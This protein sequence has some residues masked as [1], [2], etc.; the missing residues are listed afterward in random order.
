MVSQINWAKKNASRGTAS[1][2]LS[3]PQYL[4]DVSNDLS[5]FRYLVDDLAARVPAT[6]AGAA[7]L[8]NIVDMQKVH[9]HR[10]D[11]VERIESNSSEF[12]SLLHNIRREYLAMKSL[13]RECFREQGHLLCAGDWQSPVYA[14]S[15]E[16]KLNRLNAGIAEH[17]LDYKRD[18]HLEQAEYE[19]RFVA[20]YVS[21]LGNK[22]AAIAYLTNSGMAAY[23]TVLHWLAHEQGLGEVALAVEPMYFENIHLAGG[24][25]PNLVRVHSPS[26]DNLLDQLRLNNPSVVLVDA[27]TNCNDVIAQDLP[28]I[29]EWASKE[30]QQIA[31]VIDSTCVPTALLPDGFLA[32]IPDNVLIVFVESLAKHHQFGMD[33]VTG[34]VVVLCASTACHDSFRKTR[35]RF[36]GNITDV[37]AASLPQP[38]KAQL[39]ARMVRH[40]RNVRLLVEEVQERIEDHCGVISSFSWLSEPAEYAPNFHGSCFTIHLH[41]QFKSIDKYRQF[42]EQ[43]L[44]LAR[45]RNLPLSLSTSFGF[46]VSRLYVTA[47]STPFEPPFLRVAIGT[48]TVEEIEEF[49]DIIATV[50]RLLALRWKAPR[51]EVVRTAP[52]PVRKLDNG[53]R[54][55]HRHN[56]F[57]GDAAIK[58]YLN[59]ANYQKTPLVEL[60]PDLNPYADKGV[61][62]FAKLMPLVP[63]MNIKSIPAFSML[64]KAAQRGELEGIKT[65]IESSSGNTVLSLSVVARLFGIQETTAIV[66]H[67]IAPALVRMLRLFGIDVLKHP[68]PGHSMYDSVPPRSERA[69][70]LGNQKGWI[71]PGQYSNPDNPEGFASWLAPDLWSQTQGRLDILSG[72]LGTCGTIYGVSRELKKRNSDLEV[73]AC[74][75]KAGQAVPGPREKS[76][77]V[78]VA[79]PWEEAVTAQFEMEAEES[80]AASVKLLRR[81]I[82][83]GP[84]SGMNYA[85]LLR[86]LKR[87]EAEGRLQ[88]NTTLSCVFLC[89][90]SPLA[91][92]DEYFEAL[93]DEYFSAVH[94]IEEVRG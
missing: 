51:L 25:F 42:E 80:F 54:A 20:E 53:V 90:D 27:V 89:C 14:S 13:L 34:G 41:E 16:F 18:G 56:V 91:H 66:D 64:N 39:T 9:E 87:V 32:Q 72:A 33:A 86:Y 57:T 43:V 48:E 24:F 1:N 36:G 7:L 58:D 77:L 6:T 69:T 19:Q 8:Q 88:P 62:I 81:G 71:N 11:M 59:P 60:P 79:F 47:P 3:G 93:G 5:E 38:S 22:S 29:L 50:H 76:Q 52:A 73:I 82:M 45:Q 94:E 23:S 26:R 61:R 37:S 92:V 63:L 74:C 65:V 84:S 4:R 70:A 30:T 68:G 40:S 15:T 21:H 75:P 31:I 12:Q 78:D 46:D 10:L 44:D 28:T 49:A 2:V 35:A 55:L 85:G 83:G 17:K 67:S